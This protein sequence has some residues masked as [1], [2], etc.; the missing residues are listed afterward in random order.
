M[1]PATTIPT[2]NPAAA[3]DARMLSPLFIFSRGN[4][5]RMMPKDSGSTPPPAPWTTR[6]AISQPTVGDS[7]AINDPTERAT[8]VIVSIRF[9]PTTS[10]SRP[11]SGVQIE[12]ERRY[13]V[14]THVIVAWSVSSSRWSW[15]STG[16]TRDC[17]RANAATATVSTEKVLR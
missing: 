13:A 9:L 10:P 8:R 7:A 17:S 5:S 4:S 2:P 16:M 11:R 1:G 12:A 14:S 3:S 6:A 15:P